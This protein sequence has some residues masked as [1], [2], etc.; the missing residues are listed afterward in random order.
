MLLTLIA[1]IPQF[2]LKQPKTFS[3][4]LFKTKYSL[5]AIINQ[6]YF[7]CFSIYTKNIKILLKNLLTLLFSF[8]LQSK[9]KFLYFFFLF[10]I[11]VCL[12]VNFYF[13]ILQFIS[14]SNCIFFTSPT[15]FG[16]FCTLF[17]Y[18][19]QFLLIYLRIFFIFIFFSE[20]SVRS[21]S[22]KQ[23][24]LTNDTKVPT[25]FLGC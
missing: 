3:T 18:L 24:Q 19:H 4:Q 20:M 8:I 21:V 6:T 7:F 2:H 17:I 16:L 1:G 11:R 9:A 15:N 13:I 25:R 5:S 12:E 23:L 14:Y 10:W 22:Q